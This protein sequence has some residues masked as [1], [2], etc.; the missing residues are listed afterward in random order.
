V[1]EKD[2]MAQ[3]AASPARLASSTASITRS[4]SES[5]GIQCIVS[6]MYALWMA[7]TADK[8]IL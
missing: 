5:E 7:V 2:G 8:L 6:R 3:L 4:V 1:A